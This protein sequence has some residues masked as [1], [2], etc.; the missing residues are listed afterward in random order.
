MPIYD[1]RELGIP[2][3]PK[4]EQDYEEEAKRQSEI[5]KVKLDEINALKQELMD[6]KRINENE[7][8]YKD[9]IIRQ[10]E[11]KIRDLKN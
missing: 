2:P 11:D 6:L 7:I 8:C 10:L 9:A 3:R 5:Q 4:K 1:L